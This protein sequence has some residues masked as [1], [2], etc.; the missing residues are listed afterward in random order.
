MCSLNSEEAAFIKWL[1]LALGMVVEI[2]SIMCMKLSEGFIKWVPSALTFV[3]TGIGFAVLI[4]ALKRF[5]LSFA[6]AI[7]SG[8]G[9]AIVSI[10]GMVYFK[11]PVYALKIAS[12]V[13][14]TIGVIGLNIC[15]LI[16]K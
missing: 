1:I 3:L 16:Y 7:W 15:N 14:I 9:I 4:L 2:S 12:I 6:Y 8:L 10:I 11:E 5:D 13:M